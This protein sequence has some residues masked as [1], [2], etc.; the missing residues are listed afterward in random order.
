MRKTERACRHVKNIGKWIADVFRWNFSG[1][2][3]RWRRA[4]LPGNNILFARCD[5]KFNI[6]QREITFEMSAMDDEELLA[7]YE[8]FRWIFWF[9]SRLSREL[10]FIAKLALENIFL[11]SHLR[12]FSDALFMRGWDAKRKK[13]NFL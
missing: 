5:G 10:I 11:Y 2:L 4:R 9:W 7:S 1:I 13:R 3:S 12:A 6:V 8:F